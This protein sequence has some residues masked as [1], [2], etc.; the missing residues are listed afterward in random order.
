MSPRRPSTGYMKRD[1]LRVP[2]VRLPE[3]PTP[4]RQRHPSARGPA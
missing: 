2:P 4:T 3:M 1:S